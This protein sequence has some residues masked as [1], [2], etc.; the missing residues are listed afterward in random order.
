M[1]P[2]AYT[3]DGIYRSY[4]GRELVVPKDLYDSVFGESE[5]ASALL[6]RT[7]DPTALAA[8]IQKDFPTLTVNSTSKIPEHLSGMRRL[9]DALILVMMSLS[10]L[11]SVFVLLNLVNIFVGRR[12]NEVI[13]MG[14]NGFSYSERIGYLLR[15][16]VVTTVLGLLL[17]TLMGFFLTDTLVMAVEGA[18]TMFRRGFNPKAWIIA[19][20]I[21][22]A[23]AILINLF[24]FRRVK[25]YQLT[26][27]TK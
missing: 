8:E 6:V 1:K 20:L 27:L 9:F 14:V 13:I 21:E 16:T 17:G 25:K 2:H 23:F 22:A 26:E 15:E 10:V 7:N 19:C 18:D 12:K 5:A 4:I 24:A 11:M 3:V